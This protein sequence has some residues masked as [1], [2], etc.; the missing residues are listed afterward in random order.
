M[1]RK[2]PRWRFA[3][4]EV[5]RRIGEFEFVF[6]PPRRRFD[7]MSIAALA[8][9]VLT[10]SILGAQV[11][12][13]AGAAGEIRHVMRKL[14]QSYPTALEVWRSPFERIIEALED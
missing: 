7:G 3:G 4:D 13:D 2:E 6:A 11:L 14:D 1:I 10:A 12:T 9:V 5:V 8:S